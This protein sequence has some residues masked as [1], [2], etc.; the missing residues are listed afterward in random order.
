MQY[1]CIDRRAMQSTIRFSEDPQHTSEGTMKFSRSVL[2]KQQWPI[3]V[4]AGMVGA[5]ADISPWEAIRNSLLI[6]GGSRLPAAQKFILPTR[7]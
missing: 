4:Q 2:P 7:A 1:D 5:N 3:L 6:S